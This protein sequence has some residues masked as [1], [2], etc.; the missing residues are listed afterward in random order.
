MRRF[1]IG[2]VLAILATAAFTEA[3]G[4]QPWPVFALDGKVR[5]K[6]DGTRLHDVVSVE[7]DLFTTSVLTFRE[8]GADGVRK[9]AGPSTPGE[10]IIRRSVR[11]DDVLWS[12]YQQILAG[13]QDRRDV[14]VIYLGANGQAAVRFDLVQCFPSAYALHAGAG[15]A[16]VTSVEA[17]TLTCEGATR[18]GL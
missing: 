14:A 9:V 11:T 18:T 4:P 7:G 2:F 15:L 10:V 8:G 12:W 6:V 17:V 5:V 16:S 13:G 3:S 1:S